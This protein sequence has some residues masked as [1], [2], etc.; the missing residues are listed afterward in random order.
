MKRNIKWFIGCSGFYYKEWKGFFYPEKLPQKK[1]FEHYAAQFNT[2]ELNVTF[3]RFPELSFLQN[4]YNKSPDNF[5][6]SVKVPRAITH[7]K[8]FSG[9]EKL[10]KDF[11]STVQ[12]GLQNKLGCVLF[13]LPP[14]TTYSPERLQQIISSMDLSF[15]N[16]IEFRN[17]SWWNDEVR[18]ALSH[19]K[20]SFCG[21]S[22]AKLPNELNADTGI[23]YYRFHGVPVLYKSEYAHDDLKKIADGIIANK[24]IKQAC[25]YFNNTWGLAA[26][27]NAQWLRQYCDEHSQQQ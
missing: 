7:Y 15:N 16:V 3:Y 1:W 22:I 5:L 18:A 10:I 6:F 23:A 14:S 27:K 20:I 25:I 9:T 13:Q 17:I 8:K 21:V 11:Y 12:N 26:I 4:W 19:K 24:K 2:L